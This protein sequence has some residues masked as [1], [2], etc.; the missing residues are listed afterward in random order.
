MDD[1]T[2]SERKFLLSR[3]LSRLQFNQRLETTE[4]IR[5]IPEHNI[6]AFRDVQIVTS[7]SRCG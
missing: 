2:L 3:V 4:K 1:E 5:T 6:S 7:H